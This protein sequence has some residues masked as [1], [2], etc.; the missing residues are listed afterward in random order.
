MDL[1]EHVD[2]ILFGGFY[3]LL[4]DILV[5]WGFDCTH[6]SSS[7]LSVDASVSKRRHTHINPLVVSTAF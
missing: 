1:P 3:Y 4:L 6:E 7:Y 2:C 5:D